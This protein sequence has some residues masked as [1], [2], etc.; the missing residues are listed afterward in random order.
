[1]TAATVTQYPSCYPNMRYGSAVM[2]DGFTLDTGIESNDLCLVIMP[3]TAD[4]VAT[5]TSIS[6]AGVGTIALKTAAGAG[7]S[8]TVYWFAI[9]QPGG[10]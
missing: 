3:A 8:Q 1:M 6:A 5:I 7:T 10:V 4:T 2:A 9:K